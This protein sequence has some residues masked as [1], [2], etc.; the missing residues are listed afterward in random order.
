MPGS[1]RVIRGSRIG[2]SSP[3]IRRG[4]IRRTAAGV[5]DGFVGSAG[6][7]SRDAGRGQPKASE[8]GVFRRFELRRRT[9]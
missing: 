3:V 7:L 6:I 9:P 5:L 2:R 8:M 1:F 4:V